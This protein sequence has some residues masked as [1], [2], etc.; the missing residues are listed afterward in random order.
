ME[1]IKQVIAYLL[2]PET[3]VYKLGAIGLLIT[4]VFLVRVK[5]YDEAIF[6][7][8]LCLMMYSVGF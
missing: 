5:Y 3:I 4:F 2:E 8:G 6:A 7:L 1:K